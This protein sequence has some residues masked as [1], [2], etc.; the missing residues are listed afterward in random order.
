M[1]SD[2]L[3]ATSFQGVCSEVQ[4]AAEVGRGRAPR[5]SAL[6]GVL[7][8]EEPAP[9]LPVMEEV[10]DAA[11][12]RRRHRAGGLQGNG[13]SPWDLVLEADQSSRM[14]PGAMARAQGAVELSD[15]EES[16]SDL[17]VC[18]EAKHC[19]EAAQEAQTGQS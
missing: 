15:D 9:L 2:R 13:G 19:E 6:L 5:V 10:A 14:H 4:Q 7:G 8:S 3:A 17:P 18:L 11:A 12:C 16:H 1:A